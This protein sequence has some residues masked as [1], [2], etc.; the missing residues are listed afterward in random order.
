V[1]SVLAVLWLGTPRVWGQEKNDPPAD[2]PNTPVSTHPFADPVVET[3]A[4]FA[5]RKAT[6][7]GE[8]ELR[9]LL[10]EQDAKV[11]IGAYAYRVERALV[12]IDTEQH[13]G[14]SIRHLSV[15]MHE[16]RAIPAPGEKSAAVRIEAQTL[17]VTVSTT[18]AVSVA[19]DLM[20]PAEA[21]PEDEWVRQQA[22]AIRRYWQ[23]R[24]AQP[25]EREAL[26]P[27]YT[28]PQRDRRARVEAD[29]QR[30][31]LTRTGAADPATLD[32]LARINP[33][34]RSPPSPAPG[35]DPGAAPGADPDLATAD[36]TTTDPDT[37]APLPPPAD[38]TGPAGTPSNQRTVVPVGGTVSFYAERIVLQEATADEP[39]PYLMAVGKV[40]VGY[41]RPDGTAGIVLAAERA[42]IFFDPD[43]FAGLGDESGANADAVRGVYLEDNVVVTDGDFTVR[44]PRVY[45]DL[46]TNKAVL[47]EAVLYAYDVSRQVPLYLRAQTLRQESLKSWTAHN[48]KLTTSDFAIPHFAVGAQR[49]TLKQFASN[50]GKRGFRYEAETV[51]PQLGGVPVFVW[52]GVAGKTADTPLRDASV[53]YNTND[54]AILE[55]TWDMFNLIGRDA[56]DGIDWLA[57]VDW[58]GSHQLGLG[59]VLD[60]DLPDMDGLFRAYVVPDDEGEDDIGNRFTVP[61]DG[62]TRGTVLWQHKQRFREFWELNIELGY[63]SDETFLEEFFPEDALEGKP[64]ETLIYLKRQENE[65][66]FTFLAEYDLIDFLPQTTT[67]QS[68]GYSVEK[69]PEFG[70]Y[71][72]G[73]SLFDDRLTWFTENRLGRVRIRS[74]E[75]SPS[76][77]GFK[78]AQSQRLFGIAPGTSFAARDA[79]AGIPNDH[80]LRFDSR[81]ELNA[82]VRL[83]E[84]FDVTPFAAG[85]LTAYDD[86]FSGFSGEDENARLWGSVGVRTKT[87]LVNTFDGVESRVLNL[88]RLRHIVEP[89]ADFSL[90]ASSIDSARLPVYDQQVEAL[91]EGFTT[92]I[93]MRNTLQTQRGGEGRWR[94][95]DWLVIDTEAVFRSDDTDT[96]TFINRYFDYRPEYALG[97]D[98]FHGR[99]LWMVSDTLAAVADV[100]Y[101]LEKDRAVQY[102]TG[103]SIDHS[104]R[105]TSYI[106]YDVI[107]VIPSELIHAGFTYKLTTKYTLGVDQT[108]DLELD[109]FRSLQVS[110]ERKLP[111]WTMRAVVNADDIDDRTTIGIVLEPDGLDQG[112]GAE[113]TLFVR[114]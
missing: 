114:E 61:Q 56:P 90:A 22:R 93:G 74:G 65:T 71:Q 68:P 7:W 31:R 84:V 21:F 53:G 85:R 29:L 70:Y 100:T 98:H 106:E 77:R 97:G 10:L 78:P 48:A 113:R 5:A 37:A 16:P 102:R 95:V 104:P 107:D 17:L 110:V 87:Q 50:E 111:G 30:Q 69:T 11:T 86:D 55:T 13:P 73:T 41:Q 91:S 35:S 58:L 24:L 67:L 108:F 15:Q 109:R 80:R 38:R 72:L 25:V 14:Q 40:R 42:I 36:A 8:G 75:D 112:F 20:E 47:L 19:T 88:H 103:L 64:T 43:R 9:W 62:D 23:R 28:Q 6:V 3:D 39:D 81:H 94:S 33:A 1:L 4:A 27:T 12:R 51:S 54:G 44:A 26:G 99:V 66:A 92:R 49:L 60:Y 76:D 63:V 57:R 82:P 101:N 83:A 34:D 52:P 46:A 45:Y 96:Q 59:T 105:L 89:M 2:A 32:A 79:A 18:G